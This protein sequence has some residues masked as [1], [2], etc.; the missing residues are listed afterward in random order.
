MTPPSREI[1]P[2]YNSFHRTDH[3]GMLSK[4]KKSSGF[5]RTECRRYEIQKS[6]IMRGR[7]FFPGFCIVPA[8]GRYT[9]NWSET[10]LRRVFHTGATGFRSCLFLNH[11]PA[12]RTSLMNVRE[13]KKVT[14]YYHS[15]QY[16]NRF[17][18]RRKL[19]RN[20]LVNRQPIFHVNL[21]RCHSI[22]KL[23]SCLAK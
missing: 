5:A 6:I 23:S 3:S 21:F 14:V 9:D 13:A 16:F 11:H 18:S 17:R 19:R 1:C 15:W 22:L 2:V 8:A 20:A 7:N 12:D 10:S 4:K